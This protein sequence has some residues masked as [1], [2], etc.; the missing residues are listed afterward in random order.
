MDFVTGK[1]ILRY[2]ILK[3]NGFVFVS[4]ILVVLVVRLV[5]SLVRCCYN[6]CLYI[7]IN[8]LTRYWSGF[9]WKDRLR[10]EFHFV[11]TIF[12]NSKMAAPMD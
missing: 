11:F 7:F 5:F 4:W 1:I 9:R 12:E 8:C 6:L 10:G 3:V 2:S